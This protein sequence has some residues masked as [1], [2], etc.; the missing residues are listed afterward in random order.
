M[1]TTRNQRRMAAKLAKKSGSNT[2]LAQPMPMTLGQSMGE[3]QALAQRLPELM[4][5]LKDLQKYQNLPQLVEHLDQLRF[6]MGSMIEEFG[7]FDYEQRKQRAVNLRL[8]HMS[9][10]PVG[11]TD[12]LELEAQFRAEFDALQFLTY[13]PL[14]SSN[15]PEDTQTT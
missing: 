4:V 6:A 3:M 1:L 8:Q 13:L 5:M 12:L 11:V 14:L 2:G 9:P 7:R 15:D 10:L